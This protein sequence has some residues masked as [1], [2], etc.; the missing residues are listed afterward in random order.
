M[1]KYKFFLLINSFILVI[2]FSLLFIYSQTQIVYMHDLF[3][4]YSYFNGIF[5]LNFSP[6]IIP[7][8]VNYIYNVYFPNLF[9]MHLIDFRTNIIVCT[10]FNL[11]L[12]LSI[13][14]FAKGF[15]IYKNDNKNILKN[16]ESA[17]LLPLI[18][19]YVFAPFFRPIYNISNIFL[20]NNILMGTD[21]LSVFFEHCGGFILYILFTIILFNIILF[22]KKYTFKQEIMLILLSFILGLWSEFVNVAL[23]IGLIL[24]IFVNL[25]IKSIKKED[26]KHNI[27]LF[28]NPAFKK[29]TIAFFIGLIIFYFGL[30]KF[31]TSHFGT[32]SD[33]NIFAKLGENLA[34]ID[35]FNK[36]YINVF[37]EQ[38]AIYWIIILACL[39]II[40]KSCDIKKNPSTLINLFYIL[41]PI[42]SF[43]LTSYLT[44]FLQNYREG[45]LPFLF[46]MEYYSLL[47]Y[48]FLGYNIILLL[49]YVYYLSKKPVKAFIIILLCMGI[50]IGG[51]NFINIYP[52]I[53][54]VRNDNKL[55]IYNLEKLICVYSNFN[56][57][58][59]L[60]KDNFSNP[61]IKDIYLGNGGTE[62]IHAIEFLKNR[63]GI[64]YRGAILVDTIEEEQK[65]LQ[66]RLKQL[67]TDTDIKNKY[68]IFGQIQFSDLKKYTGLK[69]KD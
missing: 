32:L 39:F 30:G 14:F 63:Y 57:K 60:S 54:K 27:V 26:E 45:A 9:N 46:Q 42:I 37:F 25:I 38:P 24:I 13:M 53:L 16:W 31:T 33:Y 50:F 62:S 59:I 11:Y 4:P 21:D 18:F 64:N 47:L 15:Y 2:I 41:T 35:N 7:N 10:I 36:Y 44:V 52:Q 67:K 6:R 40:V 68:N 48:M 3:W 1:Q 43:L 20:Y 61:M 49:G 29:M 58:I 51:I 56:E 22:N 23:F 65:E 5:S 12:T 66:K 55:A 17:F 28:E 19:L 34:N 8:A 69:P